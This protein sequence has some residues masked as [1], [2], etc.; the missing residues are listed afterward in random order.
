[1]PA[2]ILGVRMTS[3]E[4]GG[5]LSRF[6]WP[7][8]CSDLQF[9][10]EAGVEGGIVGTPPY[11]LTVAPALRTPVN[12]TFEKTVRWTIM[13]DHSHPFFVSIVDSKGVTWSNGPLHAG[14]G[15][16]SCFGPPRPYPWLTLASSLGMSFS[17]L[18]IGILLAS[19]ICLWHNRRRPQFIQNVRDPGENSRIQQQHLTSTVSQDSKSRISTNNRQEEAHMLRTRTGSTSPT[20]VPARTSLHLRRPS[21]TKAPSSEIGLMRHR[22]SFRREDTSG[23]ID[24]DASPTDEVQHTF[25]P[26]PV[27]LGNPQPFRREIDPMVIA[28]WTQTN[29]SRGYEPPAEDERRGSITTSRPIL[30]HRDTSNSTSSGIPSPTASGGGILGP[31]ASLGLPSNAGRP[32]IGSNIGPAGG[33]L[34]TLPHTREVTM[35]SPQT[36]VPTNPIP[37]PQQY[38]YHLPSSASHSNPQTTQPSNTSNNQQPQPQPPHEVYV[39]HHDAGL[40][41]PVT[42]ITHHG[43][44]VT[45]LPP[46]YD[47]LIPTPQ[48]PNLNY[49]GESG[50]MEE[51]D[52]STSMRRLKNQPSTS[53][54]TNVDPQIQL[55]IQRPGG[56]GL[57]LVHA[58]D[59]PLSAVSPTSPNPNTFPLPPPLPSQSIR[60]AETHLPHS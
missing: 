28:P 31:T 26:V 3:I 35:A 18:A 45:E 47:H 56:S 48:P 40:P 55:Q 44:V 12:I 1:M 27:R 16:L 37:R 10:L 30:K 53:A 52:A 24:L 33:G 5:S 60:T 20:T 15:T 9:D 50:G 59:V 22:P 19:T 54:M 13:L 39:V 14:A 23:T 25:P 36:F 49:H 43:T 7:A 38:A 58:E 34:S 42:V 32:S 29:E 51:H 21:N 17:F 57:A 46:G 6:G 8:R 11:T 4:T 41:P 2:D